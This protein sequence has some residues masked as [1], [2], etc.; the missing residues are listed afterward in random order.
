M[1]SGLVTTSTVLSSTVHRGEPNVVEIN[2]WDEMYLCTGVKK[3]DY[4][5]LLFEKCVY[6]YIQD[7]FE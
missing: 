1:R 5:K 7:M 4:G 6:I 3:Y 2:L